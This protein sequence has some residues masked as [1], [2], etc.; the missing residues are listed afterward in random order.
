M[1]G[2]VVALITNSDVQT[3][4]QTDESKYGSY[5]GV[6]KGKKTQTSL[7]KGNIKLNMGKCHDHLISSFGIKVKLPEYACFT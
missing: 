6:K 2:V 5:M 4:E 7:R 3:T 1:N